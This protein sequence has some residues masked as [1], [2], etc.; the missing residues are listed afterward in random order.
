[1]VKHNIKNQIRQIFPSV[2]SGSASIASFYLIHSEYCLH[3]ATVL[4]S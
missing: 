3:S 2:E 4:G 1:M